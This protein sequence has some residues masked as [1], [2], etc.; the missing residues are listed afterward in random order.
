MICG[1]CQTTLR[2]GL[3]LVLVIS[4]FSRRCISDGMAIT[5]WTGPFCFCQPSSTQHGGDKH[6][7]MMMAWCLACWLAFC[8]M[9]QFAEEQG[10]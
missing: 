4:V 8:V 2:Q 9:T 3:E 5:T 1:H 6:E 10:H 7:K